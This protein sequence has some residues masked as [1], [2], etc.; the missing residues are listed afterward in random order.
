M[1]MFKRKGAWALVCFLIGCLI[2]GL[3]CRSTDE[4][5][6]SGLASVTISGNTP[7]Q[8]R[9]A[10]TD[11]FLRNGY[12]VARTDPATLVFEKQGSGMSNFAYGNWLGD[13]PIWMRVK[14]NIVPAGEMTFRLQCSAY[15]VRDR[16]G[17]TE[18]ELAVSKVRKGKYKKLLEEV[19]RQFTRK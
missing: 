5:A 17:A 9:E 7:G 2:S 18:E 19:A 1:K 10:A 6:S 11:V 14:V 16:G 12:Q 4:A 15:I 8:I 3:S 13:E